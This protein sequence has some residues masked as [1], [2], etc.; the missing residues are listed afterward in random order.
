MLADRL[1]T[2]AMIVLDDGYR[3]AER[4]IAERGDLVAEV[5]PRLGVGNHP[6]ECAG[7]FCKRGIVRHD[8]DGTAAES[9]PAGV[10]GHGRLLDVVRAGGDEQD[11]F[12]AAIMSVRGR[13]GHRRR[14][15]STR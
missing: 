5:A 7:A 14:T 12:A 15:S 8:R 4:R 3:P 6:I 2:G 11:A 13:L 10:G 1:A 9:G